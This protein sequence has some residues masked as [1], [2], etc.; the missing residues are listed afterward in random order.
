MILSCQLFC[1][2]S[3]GMDFNLD[4]HGD[5]A[6]PYVFIS[7]IEGILSFDQ[8]LDQL[9]N[10]FMSSWKAVSPDMQDKFGYPKNDPGTGN[11]MI[12]TKNLGEEFKCLTQTLEMPFKQNDN[13]P[14]EY[15][16]WSSERSIKLGESLVSA[17]LNIVDD[18]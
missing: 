14:D 12:C 8:K 3:I 13:I 10:S 6:L 1:N 11:L 5:E 2:N 9:S 15:L 16:G 7:G 4:V 17:M 18:L